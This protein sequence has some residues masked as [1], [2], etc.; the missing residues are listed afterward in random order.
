MLE[1]T[2]TEPEHRLTFPL[3][4]IT[5]AAI[6]EHAPSPDIYAHTARGVLS[7]LAHL[8]SL[9]IAHRDVKPANVMY[10]WE[11]EVKLIDLGTAWDGQGGD[12]GDIMEVQVGS[13]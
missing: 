7:A 13:G 11:G 5:L 6:L 9:G 10:D 8:H 1:Y 2:Y 3:L 4:S 12:G